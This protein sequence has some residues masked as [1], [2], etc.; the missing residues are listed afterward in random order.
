MDQVNVNNKHKHKKAAMLAEVRTSS[1]IQKYM[2]LDLL[3]YEHVVR[4]FHHQAWAYGISYCSNSVM[5]AQEFAAPMVLT[6][7]D[8]SAVQAGPHS[9]VL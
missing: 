9:Q 2:K 5:C 8:S 6:C 3:L 1:E 7:V 4:L